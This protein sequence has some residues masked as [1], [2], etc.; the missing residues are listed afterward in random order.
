MFEAVFSLIHAITASYGPLGIFLISIFEEVVAPIPL[1]FIILSAGFSVFDGVAISFA[2]VV[3]AILVIGLP[4]ALGATLGSLVW[5][6]VSYRY[7][8]ALLTHRS[9]RRWVS[10]DDVVR[11]QRYFARGR[12]D[13]LLLVV[14]RSMPLVP[15]IGLSVLC[16]LLRF[17]L[18][19]Y[20]ICT[21]LGF[22]IWASVLAVMGWRFGEVYMQVARH[23]V[24]GQYLFIGII[25]VLIGVRVLGVIRQK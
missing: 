4:A 8:K 23:F 17:P 1:S 7:G 13:E 6:G 21:F 10:W 20:V 14:L 3:R 25:L 24:F 22:F 5:Y 12:S 19:E 15:G 2:E 11:I 9:V 18:K 16:G